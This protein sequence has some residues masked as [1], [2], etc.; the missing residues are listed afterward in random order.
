MPVPGVYVLNT[1]MVSNGCTLQDKQYTN[2]QS[3]GLDNSQV[4]VTFNIVSGDEYQLVFQ[5]FQGF[6]S[7]FTLSYDV[8]VVGAGR[9]VIAADVQGNY[10]FPTGL[11]VLTVDVNEA[12]FVSVPSASDPMAQTIT[13]TKT[14]RVVNSFTFGGEA[15][16]EVSNSVIQSES[17]GE[18]GVVPEPGTYALM[19]SALLGLV[20]LR[21]KFQA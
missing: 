17:Q 20:A 2:F 18:E 4:G 9:Q 5:K 6:S 16:A 14:V 12:N 15:L 19:G 8:I 11:S 3:T 21:R 1:L 7:N 10:P 13:P